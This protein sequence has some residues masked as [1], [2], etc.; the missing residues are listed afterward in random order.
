VA[1]GTAVDISIGVAS[2][3]VVDAL[4]ASALVVSCS[5]RAQRL[6]ATRLRRRVRRAGAVVDWAGVVLAGAV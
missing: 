4:V 2:D 6:S 5:R 1:T 3:V